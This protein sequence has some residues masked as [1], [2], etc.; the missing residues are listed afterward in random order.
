MQPLS[1]L[2][3]RRLGQKNW[4]ARVLQATRMA[5][6]Q[7]GRDVVFWSAFHSMHTCTQHDQA[8]HLE[9][10][11]PSK[12]IEG[13]LLEKPEEPGPEDCCQ[14]HDVADSS[15]TVQTVVTVIPNRCN[16]AFRVGALCVSGTCTGTICMSTGSSRPI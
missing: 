14:V 15:H 3:L 16:F 6:M 8:E 4:S 2:V 11:D 10:V 7:P 9:R 12:P 1:L 13:P 5:D